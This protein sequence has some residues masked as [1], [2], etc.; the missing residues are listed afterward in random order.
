MK[1]HSRF[2]P[3]ICAT[4]CKKKK[5]KK[6]LFSSPTRRGVCHHIAIKT[7][8]PTKLGLTK[9]WQLVK[10]EIVTYSPSRAEIKLGQVQG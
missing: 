10:P 9:K 5:K 8:N 4:I 7:E 1:K 3:N 2:D 6:E